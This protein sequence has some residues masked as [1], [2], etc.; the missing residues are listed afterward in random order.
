MFPEEANLSTTR[1]CLQPA[2]LEGSKLEPM[3]PAHTRFSA[4]HSTYV[5]GSTYLYKE[6]AVAKSFWHI[7]RS[8]ASSYSTLESRAKARATRPAASASPVPPRMA[9]ARKAPAGSQSDASSRYTDSVV[10]TTHS[11]RRA[12]WRARRRAW[13]LR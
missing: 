7:L 9:R 3:S 5:L 4:V 11:S 1:R 6:M 13:R 10:T 8:A 12:A 2:C